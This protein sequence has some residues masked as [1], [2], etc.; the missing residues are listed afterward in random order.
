MSPKW[1]A[2]APPYI[3]EPEEIDEMVKRLGQAIVEELGNMQN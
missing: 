2:V 3:I 1:V